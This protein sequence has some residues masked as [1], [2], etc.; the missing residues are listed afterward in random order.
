MVLV[1]RWS[2]L[3]V[4]VKRSLC[5]YEVQQ[6]PVLGHVYLACASSILKVFR[7]PFLDKDGFSGTY[8][9]PWQSLHYPRMP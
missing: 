9:Q 4:P 7:V 6:L 5:V 1:S 3:Y 2:Q 8:P